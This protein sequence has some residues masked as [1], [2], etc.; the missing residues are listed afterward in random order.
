MRIA[1][2]GTGNL[3]YHLARV[4]A[5]GGH[6]LTIWNRT[7]DKAIKT[8]NDTGAH[9]CLDISTL[10]KSI[11]ICFLCTSENALPEILSLLPDNQYTLVHTAGSIPIDVLQSHSLHFGVFYPLQ[12]FLFRKPLNYAS[13]P[14]FIE[15]S[16]HQTLD[17]LHRLATTHFGAGYNL[18]SKKRIFLH[19]AAIFASNFTNAM[20][21][22]A[23]QIL[24][25]QQLDFQY[26][27]PLI[28]ETLERLQTLNPKISQTGPAAR[29]NTI[30]IQK[31]L[32][33]LQGCPERAELYRIITQY[34]QQQT[35]T[36][37]E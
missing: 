27:R 34:I 12:S 1:I 33:L 17:I 23:E 30:I 4:F 20:C 29:N 26:L 8:A 2:L 31:H 13:I 9:I 18:D 25:E 6:H 35:T 5:Q 14:V 22:L 11:D 3:G 15:A 19:I 21:M 24:Q 28:H 37:N 10:P 32:A 7:A 16:D 36:R